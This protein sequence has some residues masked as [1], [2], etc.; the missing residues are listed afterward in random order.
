MSGRSGRELR[1]SMRVWDTPIRLF[2]WSLVALVAGCYASQQ[3]YWMELH[4]LCGYGVL[5][6]LVFRVAWGFVGSETARFARF[7]AGPRA[8]LFHLARLFRREPD[9]QIGH[10]AAGGWMV[11][12]LL[13]LLTGETVSGLFSNDDVAATGPLAKYITKP[14]SDLLSGLH[15]LGW[16][17]LLGAIGLHVLA[18]AV[19]A[20]VKRHDLVGPMI[21]GKKRLP[22]TLRPPRQANPALAAASLA[23]GLALAAAIAWLA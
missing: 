21:T 22:A 20:L 2:H 11:V 5:A 17:I 6:L 10:N 7:L 19:Y 13:A 16:D 9:L 12:A 8:A 23:A 18:I 3:L 1:L 15:D 4:A 14:T